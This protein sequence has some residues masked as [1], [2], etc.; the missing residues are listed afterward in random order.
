MG[1]ASAIQMAR[2]QVTIRGSFDLGQEFVRNGPEPAIETR[3]ASTPS[4]GAQVGGAGIF[5]I[6]TISV[7]ERTAEIGLLRAL[8][9]A[10][11]QVLAL[12]LGEAAFLAALGGVAGLILGA[13]GAWLLG[14]AMPALPVHTP[15]IYVVAAEAM[16]I[17]IGL[18][19]GVLPATR[20]AHLEPVDALHA[21]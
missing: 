12:F 14:V 1:V 7:R 17:S 20:A 2:S 16:A 15:L 6:M 5:T 13:G 11:A 21:E 8:G 4:Q 3:R 19:A 9:A 10:R 18:I